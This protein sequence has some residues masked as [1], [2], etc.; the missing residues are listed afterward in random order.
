MA[1]STRTGRA[2]GA[3]QGRF[4]RSTSSAA[5]GRYART[6]STPRRRVPTPGL[7]RRQP[8]PSGLKKVMGAVI[9]TAATKKATPSSK[10]GKAGG[11][12]LAAA[13]AGMAFKNRG[14]LNELR[15]K[16]SGGT[17]TTPT[18]VDN[19]AAPPATPAV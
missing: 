13:A 12:A 8:K 9:P 3:G 5:K 11:L 16:Q 15:R 1:T 18:T 14:K 17:S 6:T 19:A 4:G 2:S 7:R 10:K